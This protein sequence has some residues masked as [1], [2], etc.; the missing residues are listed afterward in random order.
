MFDFLSEKISTV[1]TRITGQRKL[2]EQNIKEAIDAVHDSLLEADVPFDVVKAFIEQLTA[3][4]VGTKLLSSVKPTEQFI[5][6]AHET[7]THFL[8]CSQEVV[9]LSTK[10]KLVVMVLGLQGSGKTTTVGKLARYLSI[11]TKKRTKILVASVDFYRPAAIDQL[12]IVASQV[13]VDFYR[14]QSTDVVTAAVEIKN[15]FER[16]NYDALFLD[17]AGRLHVE[18][19]MLDELKHIVAA[20]KPNEKVL[21]LDAMTGQESLAVAKAFNEAVG[22]DWAVL[23]KMD[24]DSRAG[25]AFAFAFMLSKPIQFIGVGE[26]VSELERFHPERAADRILGMGDLKT[27]F[28]KIDR[29]EIKDSEKDQEARFNRM[30]QGK[31]TLE[32]FASQ[33]HMMSNIGSI[34]QLMQYIPGLSAQKISQQQLADGERGMKRFQAALSS[35]TRKERMQPA[36]LNE[37]RKKRIASGAGISV[38]DVNQLLQKFEESQQFAKLMRKRGLF[39]GW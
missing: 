35:M 26:K 36:I 24:S 39:S 10:N 2:T 7:L 34:T 9:P 25:A 3:K 20:V 17:T 19:A 14:A 5:K 23:S 31:M 22:F 12:E 29:L 32:D 38:A 15:Y 1:F 8:S 21:V 18:S 33:M 11:T 13:G 37:S 16:Q 30:M 27:L 4:T 28:E 6:I